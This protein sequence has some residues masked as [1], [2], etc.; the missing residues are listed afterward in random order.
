MLNR[1]LSPPLP[2]VEEL[3]QAGGISSDPTA[4]PTAGGFQLSKSLNNPSSSTESISDDRS[5]LR[6]MKNPLNYW[7]TKDGM[8]N[9]SDITSF[10]RENFDS[11]N[12]VKESNS[13]TQSNSW[14]SF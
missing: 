6:K 12:V 9:T 13:L 11:G 4:P 14:W 3:Q 2:S 5:I 10:G 8:T 1:M 7:N